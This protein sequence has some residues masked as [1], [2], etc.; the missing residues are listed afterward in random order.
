ML[1][2]DTQD[3]LQISGSTNLGKRAVALKKMV[4]LSVKLLFLM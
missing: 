2:I 3:V 1:E 4:K